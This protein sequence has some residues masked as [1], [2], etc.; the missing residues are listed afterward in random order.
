[1]V[2]YTPE[3]GDI[4]WMSFDPQVGHEHAGLRPAVILSPAAYNARVGLALMC[5]IT[6]KSKGFLFEVPIPESL[7][8]YVSGVIL[9]DQVKSF[10]WRARRAQYIAALPGETLAVVTA[11]LLAILE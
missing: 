4:V 11:K 3:R 8:E 1:M 5:P 10:D 6:S 2:A 9:S 7:S